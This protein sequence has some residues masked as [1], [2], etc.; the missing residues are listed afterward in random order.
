MSMLFQFASHHLYSETYKVNLEVNETVN[1]FIPS[2]IP[3]ELF[4]QNCS[5]GKQPT[6]KLLLFPE[7]VP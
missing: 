4:L 3:N 5:L 1:F 2:K 6:K 7:T